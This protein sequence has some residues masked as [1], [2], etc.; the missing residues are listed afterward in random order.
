MGWVLEADALGW[1]GPHLVPASFS[2]SAFCVILCQ[3]LELYLQP[4]FKLSK[5]IQGQHCPPGGR[6]PFLQN[7]HEQ[8]EKETAIHFE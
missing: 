8:R 4:W 3:D 5:S 2:L 7:G 1:D 6:E